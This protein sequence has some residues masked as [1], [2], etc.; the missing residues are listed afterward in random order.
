MKEWRC[1][2]RGEARWEGDVA[3]GANHNVGSEVPEVVEALQEGLGEADGEE[4]GVVVGRCRR[5]GGKGVVSDRNCN[6]LHTVRDGEEEEARGGIG[7]FEVVV[8]DKHRIDVAID[9]VGKGDT[10]KVVRVVT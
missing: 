9:G 5:D 7:S 10:K 4:K 6:G 8:Y 1:E 2:H 3:A